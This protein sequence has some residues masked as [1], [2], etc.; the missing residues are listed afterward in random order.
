MAG[1]TGGEEIVGLLLRP[2]ASARPR[3]CRT[4]HQ[5]LRR[6]SNSKRFTNRQH[7]EDGVRSGWCLPPGASERTIEMARRPRGESRPQRCR[8]PAARERRPRRPPSSRIITPAMA[9]ASPAVGSGRGRHLP[10]E[11][12]VDVDSIDV[13][14]PAPGRVRATADLRALRRIPPGV[15]PQLGRHRARRP[16]KGLRPLLEPL[17]PD[18]GAAAADHRDDQGAPGGRV[19]QQRR[20]RHAGQRRPRADHPHADG[21]PTPDD[22]DE[23][24]TKVWK[25]PAFFLAHPLAIAAFGRECTSRGVPPP[26]VSLFGSQ[27]ITWRGVPLIPSD[28]VGVEGEQDQDPSPADR[29]EA[30]GGRRALPARAHRRAGPGTRRPLHGDQP[31][32]PSPP[33]SSPSTARWPS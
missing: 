21:P 23:L 19:D 33:T 6:R 10:P 2:S 7:C 12:G 16:H 30:P 17:R 14:L 9:G 13:G 11:Q 1:K 4:V 15:L 29:R 20:L 5:S 31:A 18:Q 24:L 27:F 8:S 3:R 32:A 28:K 25:E 26:T 22:L